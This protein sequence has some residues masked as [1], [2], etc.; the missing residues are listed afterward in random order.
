[1]TASIPRRRTWS[2]VMTV[3]PASRARRRSRRELAKSA[4]PTWTIRCP[5][6]PASSSLRTGEPLLAPSRRS[7]WASR[8]TRPAVCTSSAAAPN[9]TGKV[10]ELSPPSATVSRATR[11]TARQQRD[12][13]LLPRRSVRPLD[14]AEV[15]DPKARH[16]DPAR[17]RP[18]R[19]PEERLAHRGRRRVRAGGRQ[20]RAPRRYPDHGQVDRFGRQ[21]GRPA[22]REPVPGAGPSRVGRQ[23]G[24]RRI[25]PRSG[26]RRARNAPLWRADGDPVWFPSAHRPPFRWHADVAQLVAHHLAK[27]RVAGSNPVVRSKRS[28]AGLLGGVAERRGNGLQSRVRGFKSRRHLHDNLNNGRL[29]QGLARFLDTEEVTGSNPVSPTTGTPSRGGGSVVPAPSGRP[30]PSPGTTGRDPD[31]RLGGPVTSLRHR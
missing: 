22:G 30:S 28:R 4:I 8:V 19:V 17:L 5:G 16:V 9:I 25:L 26:R 1:M 2:R 20:R 18:G 21:R 10:A 24:H 3:M 13:A 7:W 23:T 29:A 31:C 12:D 27:V 14:V 11:P 15:D 6:T